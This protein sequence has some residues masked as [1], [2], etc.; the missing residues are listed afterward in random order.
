M[1]SKLQIESSNSTDDNYQKMVFE[2]Q[3]SYWQQYLI[4]II[5]HEQNIT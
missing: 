1:L 3:A 2:R 4:I 5:I